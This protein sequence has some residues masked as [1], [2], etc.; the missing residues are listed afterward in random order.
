M[1]VWW[2]AGLAVF[3]AACSD[4]HTPQQ[5]QFGNL[6]FELPDTWSEA[7]GGGGAD[8]RMWVPTENDRRESIVMIRSKLPDGVSLDNL[9][10]L[11]ADAQTGLAS[12]RP[13]VA[14][15]ELGNGLRG[16][17]V[18]FDY[19][20]PGHPHPYHRVHTVFVDGASLIHVFYTAKDSDPT[21]SALSG[22]L[23]TLHAS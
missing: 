17:R 19:I 23:R 21:L 20:P 22:V 9:S 18:E 7:S 12:S 2:L 5:I 1:R 11:L 15:A 14:T 10:G 16:A 13:Q 4:V 8:N 3:G 6:G